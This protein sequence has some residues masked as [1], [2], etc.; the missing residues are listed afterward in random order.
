MRFNKKAGTIALL[1]LV[2]VPAPSAASGNL[3][4]Q[5]PSKQKPASTGITPQQSRP[6]NK[7]YT[8]IETTTNI[9]TRYEYFDDQ[10]GAQQQADD[11]IAT[12]ISS[13]LTFRK[14]PFALDAE[15]VDS[16]IFRASIFTPLGT[17]DINTT[18]P[19]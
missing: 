16:R 19:I 2:C 15:L 5:V 10:F 18:E 14:G 1:L 11:I 9:R 3:I 17:D 7:E 13:R 4:S 6:S 12:R 8:S